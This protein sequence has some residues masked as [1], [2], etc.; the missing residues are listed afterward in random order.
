[1]IR[2]LFPL[3]L[4]GLGTLSA[5]GDKDTDTGSTTDT[6][7]DGGGD[8]D[9]TD[10][11][12]TDDTDMGD[13]DTDA[14]GTCE[15]DIC[16]T[17]GA[18]VPIASHEITMAAASDPMFEAD[19]APLV[20]RGPDAVAAF[21]ESLANFITDAYGCTQNA[22]T[23]PTMQEAHAGMDIT[24]DEYTAFVGLIAAQLTELGV[25]E[26]D[27]NYCFAPVLTDPAFS[28]TIIGQ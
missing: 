12:D 27:I 19:F 11:G 24:A 13:T 18:A 26:N 15:T 7:T 17:Y 6:D 21:E 20:A 9:D 1:M 5:C 14:M 28:S 2:T 23:G 3:A 4:L 10:M 25:P 8:T 16:A 22:Y